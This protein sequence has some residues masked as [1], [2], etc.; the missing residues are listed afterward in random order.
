MAESMASMVVTL[1]DVQLPRTGQKLLG[2]GHQLGG[3]VHAVV[4]AQP[5]DMDAVLISIGAGGDDLGALLHSDRISGGAAGEI[6]G[7]APAL[8]VGLQGDGALH[9]ANGHGIEAHIS[10][11]QG[12][13]LLVVL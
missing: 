11:G 9:A 3:I 10:G 7:L 1:A 2:I 12:L 6:V 8:G 5:D 13:D 4:G